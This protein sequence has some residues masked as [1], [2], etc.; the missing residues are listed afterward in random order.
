MRFIN[1]FVEK[2]PIFDTQCNGIDWAHYKHP[3]PE[4]VYANYMQYWGSVHLLEKDI[5]QDLVRTNLINR[6]HV[7][8]GL[9]LV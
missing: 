7:R 8:T 6:V 1:Y 9:S 4:H 5:P 2:L 3:L